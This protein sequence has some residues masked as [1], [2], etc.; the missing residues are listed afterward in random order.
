MGELKLDRE[1]R[2]LLDSYESGEWH[3]INEVGAEA[4]RYREYARATFKKDRRVNI[5]L[6][7]KDLIGIQKRALEEGVPYQTLIAS[8]IHKYVSG[9][10][11]ERRSEPQY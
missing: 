9:N 7:S 5:R 10:L 2:E 6:S 11:V 8:I 3:S 1:E 4:Q